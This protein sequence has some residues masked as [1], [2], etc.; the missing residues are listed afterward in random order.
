MKA[1]ILNGQFYHEVPDHAADRLRG[2]TIVHVESGQDSS[3]NHGPARIWAIRNDVRT[4]APVVLDYLE[5]A[6]AIAN[7]CWNKVEA[8]VRPTVSL[9]TV[10]KALKAKIEKAVDDRLNT[11]RPLLDMGPDAL[12]PHVRAPKM[13]E[14]AASKGVTPQNVWQM[15]CAYWQFAGPE[16][17]RPRNALAGT[18]GLQARIEEAKSI[19]A[20]ADNMSPDECFRAYKS[21][22]KPTAGKLEGKVMGYTDVM[23][24]RRGALRYLFVPSPDGKLTYDFET[25]YNQTLFAFYGYR[26][27]QTSNVPVPSR[28]QFVKAVTTAPNFEELSMR[29]VGRLTAL[30]SHRPL[31]FT[32]KNQALAAGHYLQVD[33][34]TTKCQLVDSVSRLP[35]GTGRVFV[36]VDTWSGMIVGGHDTLSGSDYESAKEL[37]VN[38]AT[39]KDVFFEQQRL[40]KKLLPHVNAHG[41][42]RAMAADGGPLAAALGSMIPKSICP[43]DTM[44]PYRPDL[45]GDIESSFNSYLVT[46]ARNLP[47]YNRVDRKE[48]EDPSITA[49]L[50]PAEFRACYW[51]FVAEYNIRPRNG[52]PPIEVMR[53]PK[54]ERPE[55]C[56]VDLL[57]WSLD[58]LSGSLSE[59]PVLGVRRALLRR[60]SGTFS[61]RRGLEFKMLRY[62]IVGD[63]PSRLKST[64]VEVRYSE[65]YTRAIDIWVDGK[66][67]TGVLSA[68][69]DEIFGK[70]TFAEVD[71]EYDEAKRRHIVGKSKQ[72]LVKMDGIEIREKQLKSAEEHIEDLWG[73]E[74]IRRRAA[75]GSSAKSNRSREQKKQREDRAGDSALFTDHVTESN[76]SA[77][78]SSAIPKPLSIHQLTQNK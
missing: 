38:V 47:G 14:I 33:D 28:D 18:K 29:I 15:L 34:V 44:A 11:L 66:V 20:K 71:R 67:F 7:G 68:E 58:H 64:K 59:K 27:D 31:K 62:H 26:S 46:W 61:T 43:L 56:P 63:G 16:G 42:W 40:E 32:T 24:C 57:Q 9:D 21:G 4:S 74:G 53:V 22:R 8:P 6:S 3:G 13:A 2:W 48:H 54:N 12:W 35:L 1:R 10:D 49:K 77:S 41:V 23:R 39:P 75:K 76:G 17:L 70:M 60:A 51:A 37:I 73:S 19:A 55:N 50:T 78:T 72:R 69:D 45:K 25:A 52:Y 5:V 30:R 36:A 65:T